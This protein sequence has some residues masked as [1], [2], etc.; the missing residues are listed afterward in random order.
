[1]TFPPLERSSMSAFTVTCPKYAGLTLKAAAALALLGVAAC[2]STPA[3]HSGFLS[4]YDG[5][6]RQPDGSRGPEHRREDAASDQIRD[7]YIEPAVLALRAPSPLSAEEQAMVLS[8]VDRQICFEV[9][10]RFTIVPAPSPEAGTIR[11]AIVRID[12]TNRV[13]SAVS[14]AAGFFIPVPVVKF[15][16]PM[17]TGGL[18]IESELIAPDGHQVAAVTWARQAEMVGRAEPSLS[19]IGD[20]LQLAEPMGDA[21]GDAF[22]TEARQ[23]RDIPDPDPC[24]RYGSR[25]NIGRTVANGVVGFATGLYV[26]QVAGTGSATVSEPAQPQPEPRPQP[27]R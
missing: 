10:E 1:M 3:A 4:A 26:P 17:T 5:L 2:Q 7:V 18:A 20:A 23:V 8:E 16:A 15:R 22:S 27:R 19:R 21:V 11:T 6:G 13:G 12:T 24:A 9:S 14:A 25:R